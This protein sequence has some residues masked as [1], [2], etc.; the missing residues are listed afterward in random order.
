MKKVNLIFF[1]PEFIKGGAANSIHSLCSNLNKNKYKIFIIC[2]NKFY[3]NTEFKNLAKIITLETKKTLFSQ[4]KINQIIF[5][6]SKNTKSK[7]IFISNLF[8]VNVLTGL[9]KINNKNIKYIFI[10]RTSF[11]ELY[12]YF[13]FIDF[14]KKF[15]IR[16]LVKITYKH[17]DLLISN[18]AKVAKDISDYTSLKTHFIYPGAFKGVSLKKKI[19]LKKRKIQ[20]V[21]IGRLSQE[22]GI[23]D[24][25]NV[26][27]EIR[28]YNFV[29][30]IIGDGPKKKN[31]IDFIK[32]E[33]IENKVKL[34]G[35]Q[36]NISLFLKK[37]DLLINT[38]FFE[39]FPNVVVE[40]LNYKVPVICSKSGGGIYEIL[41][42]GKYGD[43]YDK[44]D[45]F[46]LKTKVLKHI[47]NPSRL[48]KKSNRGSNDLKRF[49]E[50]ISAKKY[51]KLIDSLRF[52]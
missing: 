15:I 11:N 41:K 5:K 12:T 16:F 40:A 29:L 28:K 45:I 52:Q 26:V 23:E 44:G 48:I 42:D 20:I 38:S 18:S 4:K 34:L 1:L 25:L 49:S 19:F 10:D 47:K 6:I 7:T 39:G 2:L 33:N 9:F 24:I 27:K 32:S 30:N 3:Y 36:K 37:S 13:N 46:S 43:L 31:I 51:E 22:K 14:F 8:H 21:W 50:K 35:H 17:A